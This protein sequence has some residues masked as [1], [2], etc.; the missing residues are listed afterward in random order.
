MKNLKI[1]LL[2]LLAGIGVESQAQELDVNLQ[3]RPRFEYR[4]GYKSLLKDNEE[5]TSQISQRSRLN[6]NY[7]QDA[8]TVKLTFQNTR[9]WGDVTTTATADKNGVAVFEGWAQYDFTE[10]WSAR[11]GRQ[12]LSYDNQ[13]IM[14]E[15]DW[16]QQ[17]QSHDALMVSFHPKNHQLDMG[18]AYNSN[19]ENTV[20]T[21]YTI[22]NYKTMQYAWYHTTFDKIGASLLLLNTGYEFSRTPTIPNPDLIIDYMQT[23]GTYLT[24]KTGK[25]DGNLSFYGQTGKSTDQQV[26]AYDAAINIG[27]NVTDSFKAGLG[28]EFL[29]G[30]ATTD[31]SSVIKS[32]NPIFGTNHGFNGYMDYFYVGNHLKN[33]GLQD[34]FLK[35]NYNS[36][37]WQ[38]AL[39]PHVFLAAADV[40]TPLNEKMDSYLG[41]EIDA[42]FGY[43][44]RKDINVSGGYSQMF[45]S[46]TM[47]FIKGGDA[48][49]TNNWAWLMISVNPRIFTWKK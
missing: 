40:V 11:M 5:G 23:F 42:T 16:A 17:G 19:A 26:S 10:K 22:A 4:N 32:F 48:G 35:L 46:K 20:Q 18:L 49:H 39:I 15:M 38:F 24:Y 44:F 12:V 29:S 47:E 21:P 1:I 28:Y 30:K 13:R 37:K 6:F 31:G 7:K 33:V 43:S 3:I 45:G 14:G 9:T 25:I 41:T 27:Y 34:A 2:L 8:L 36:N